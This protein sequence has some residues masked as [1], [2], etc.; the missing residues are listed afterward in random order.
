MPADGK[1]SLFL[2]RGDLKRT[3]VQTTIYKRMSSS[4]STSATR[5]VNL[6]IHPVLVMNKERT[7]KCLRQVQHIRGHL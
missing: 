4:C 7:G 2:W 3:K 5:R 6:V 1:S